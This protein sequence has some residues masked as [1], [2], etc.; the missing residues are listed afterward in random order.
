LPSKSG[1]EKASA[2]EIEVRRSRPI[3]VASS[4]RAK[5]SALALPS[6]SV[7]GTTTACEGAPAHST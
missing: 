4:A 2:P 7:H 1:Y 6:I 3:R 5:A